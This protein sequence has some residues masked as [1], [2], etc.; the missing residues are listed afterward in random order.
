MWV[1]KLD[2]WAQP[3]LGTAP[4]LSTGVGVRA[5]LKMPKP[6]PRWYS[7]QDCPQLTNRPSASRAMLT[8]SL[9]RSEVRPTTPVRLRPSSASHGVL[10]PTAQ[11]S[12]GTVAS[13]PPSERVRRPLPTPPSRALPQP[14]SEL[15]ALRANA[16]S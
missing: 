9:K 10:K 7:Q 8:V 16:T 2:T 1:S 11:T 4:S 14:H 5:W 13:S 12:V 6:P 15:S 3:L